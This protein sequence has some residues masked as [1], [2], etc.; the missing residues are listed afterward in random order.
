M[1]QAV[2]AFYTVRGELHIPNV[3][4]VCQANVKLLVS[5]TRLDERIHQTQP[6]KTYMEW[7]SCDLRSHNVNTTVDVTKYFP[8]TK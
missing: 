1:N 3:C 2:P 4:V 8:K 6:G 7:A 5:H